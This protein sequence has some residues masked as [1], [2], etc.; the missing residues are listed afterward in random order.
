MGH[1]D[2]V[3]GGAASLRRS[4]LVFAWLVGDDGMATREL[5]FVRMNCLR[6]S[7]LWLEKT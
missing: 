4:F 1:D 2:D 5:F 3:V 6:L 7:F